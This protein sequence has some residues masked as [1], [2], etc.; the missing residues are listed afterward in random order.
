MIE[1]YITLDDSRCSRHELDKLHNTGS[2]LKQ[3][4]FL[5]LELEDR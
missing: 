5:D 3:L 2:M 4:H 1:D